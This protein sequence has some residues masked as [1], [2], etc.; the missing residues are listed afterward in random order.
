MNS[1]ESLF[2][3]LKEN[4]QAGDLLVTMGAG[5]VWQLSKEWLA[6]NSDH[7]HM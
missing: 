4:L 5:D 2:S 6:L 1:K 7:G 3:H